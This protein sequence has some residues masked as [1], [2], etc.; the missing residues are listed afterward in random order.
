[1]L[2]FAFHCFALLLVAV[3]ALLKNMALYCFS[4]LYL[5]LLVER[6]NV[7]HVTV[8][9]TWCVHCVE[10]GN[11]SDKWPETTKFENLN[12]TSVKTKVN[13]TAFKV[14]KTG[15]DLYIEEV[16]ALCF[17]VSACFCDRWFGMSYSSHYVTGG[18]I[19]WDRQSIL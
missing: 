1:M 15:G 18:I 13:T 14:F 11:V 17:N 7:S 10:E 2:R 6:G 16:L 19:F 3:L 8:Y 9:L 4:L 12:S 5:A